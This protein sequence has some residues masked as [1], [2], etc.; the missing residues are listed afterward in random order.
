V[1]TANQRR[2]VAIG[3][4]KLEVSLRSLSFEASSCSLLV[5]SCPFLHESEFDA[6]FGASSKVMS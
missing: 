5:S 6:K 4:F 1:E 2:V 3:D